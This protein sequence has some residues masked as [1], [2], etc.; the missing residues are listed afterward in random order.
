MLELITV[1]NDK[2][3][4]TK[5]GIEHGLSFI[6][7]IENKVYLFDTGQTN[8]I[9]KNLDLMNLDIKKIDSIILSHGHYDHTGGLEYLINKVEK[10]TIF[11][12]DGFENEKYS[13]NDGEYL[14]KGNP[15]NLKDRKYS[16]VSVIRVDE[17]CR[18]INNNIYLVSKFNRDSYYERINQKFYV[19][20][21]GEYILDKFND[22]IVLC[23]EHEEGMVI[24]AG[25]SHP[26][27][28]NIVSSIKEIFNKPIYAVIGGFH[29]NGQDKAYITEVVDYL[30]DN[31]K[32]IGTGHC[33]GEFAEMLLKERFGDNYLDLF[34]GKRH[35]L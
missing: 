22:E 20:Q 10:E 3:L 27:I 35:K 1:M 7:R 24:F 26:G 21:N 19:K 32:V 18:T 6:I 23:Y 9:L 2:S 28:V 33:T 12:G 16:N 17:I 15:I 14:Y 31:V 13:Y 4:D 5:F 29:L 25:C 8:L 11:I 30:S 34:V